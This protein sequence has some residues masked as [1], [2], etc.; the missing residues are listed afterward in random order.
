MLALDIPPAKEEGNALEG[1]AFFEKNRNEDLIWPNSQ[2]PFTINVLFEKRKIVQK[3]IDEFHSKIVQIYGQPLVTWISRGDE[4]DYVEF[5]DAER[6]YSTVGRAKSGVQ[7]IGLDSEVTTKEVIH[8]MCHAI[9]LVHEHQRNDRE[10]NG[11]SVV[12]NNNPNYKKLG[13]PLGPYDKFSIMHYPICSENG[14]SITSTTKL[15]SNTLTKY[16]VLAIRAI[17]GDPC[18]TRDLW[19]KNAFEQPATY[20]STCKVLLCTIC[21]NKHPHVV[22]F[23]GRRK[24]FYCGS[25]F[26]LI[27]KETIST[28]MKLVALVV[29]IE[30]VRR[31]YKLAWKFVGYNSKMPNK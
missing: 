16:D 12:D 3:A 2:V 15:S 10:K 8:E 27:T 20:C 23:L 18:C 14:C 21:S 9:G 30:I 4:K 28:G 25:R 31:N 6:T 19:G 29:A 11:V 1:I 17:Y 5:I 26:F 7:Y 22:N 24:F 13:N